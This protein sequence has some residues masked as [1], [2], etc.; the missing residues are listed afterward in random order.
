MEIVEPMKN[1][2]IVE[3]T[4]LLL[5]RV[6]Y[7][8]EKEK[9]TLG[10]LITEQMDDLIIKSTTI[11]E[12]IFQKK[13]KIYEQ[14]DAIDFIRSL[15]E[16][17]KVFAIYTKDK[18]IFIGMI[19][20]SSVNVVN[21]NA[22]IGY[23]LGKDYRGS[24]YMEEAAIEIIRHGFEDLDFH[25]INVSVFSF[26]EASKRLVLKL[27]FKPCGISREDVY[28]EGVYFNV[29]SFDLLKSEWEKY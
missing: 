18:N 13:N 1:V 7:L 23:W 12:L 27:G 6:Q 10:F 19:G 28:R 15:S 20:L 26:N 29:E 24:G 17:D 8:S 9:E 22:E 21:N 3:T 25:K 11:I 14:D 5:K 16:S 4:R 2:G